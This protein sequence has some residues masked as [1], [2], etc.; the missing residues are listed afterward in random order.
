MRMGIDD[1]TN[2]TSRKRRTVETFGQ[3]KYGSKKILTPSN[4]ILKVKK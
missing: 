2:A 1:T 4:R 3:A